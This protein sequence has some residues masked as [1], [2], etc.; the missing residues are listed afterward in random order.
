LPNYFG[1][2]RFGV[3]GDNALAGRRAIKSRG[4][5]GPR[6]SRQKWLRAL[7]LNA[8]QSE[9]F[10]RWL[11]GRVHRGEF[12]C[13]LT[14]DIAKKTDTGGLFEVED[15]A[16]EQPRLDRGEITYT[17]PIYGHK[18]RSASGEAARREAEVL[19]AEKVSQQDLKKAGLKGSRRAARLLPGHISIT[20]HDEEGVQCL[21]FSFTLPKGS[22]ATTL[23]REFI[24]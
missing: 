24:K 20:P 7:M 4:G 13:L 18:M 11:A 16:T 22:Y 5:R 8:Y 12:G 23:L 19:E 15:P 17:G 10:N 14:G 3:D 6:N 9:L 21:W 2:Q 1:E